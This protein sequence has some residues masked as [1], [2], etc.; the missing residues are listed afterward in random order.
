M[1]ILGRSLF[2][3]IGSNGK[4]IPER[5]PAGNAGLLKTREYRFSTPSIFG[6]VA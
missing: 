2:G 6:G 1:Y 5:E 4:N 3:N